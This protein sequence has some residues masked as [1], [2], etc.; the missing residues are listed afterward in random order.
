MVRPAPDRLIG[1]LPFP[2]SAVF[3]VSRPLPDPLTSLSKQPPPPHQGDT[4]GRLQRDG[5]PCPHRAQAQTDPHLKAQ[6]PL[7][8]LT[9]VT[10]LPPWDR[11]SLPLMEGTE[12]ARLP[13][14]GKFLPVT[15]N[16]WAGTAPSQYP[17]GDGTSPP[18]QTVD[19]SSSNA[20]QSAGKE[21]A[22]APL[23]AHLDLPHPGAPSW[24]AEQCESVEQHL[25]SKPGELSSHILPPEYSL[26]PVLTGI[27]CMGW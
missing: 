9:L 19:A 7:D 22:G 24:Q 16:R 10:S 17:Q 6:G 14:R 13:L 23:I 20:D 1:G 26:S 25:P 3:S 11:E 18:G 27:I 15:S 21:T 5:L 4:L 2:N 12:N 8:R